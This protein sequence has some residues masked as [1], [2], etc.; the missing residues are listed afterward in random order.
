M[1]RKKKKKVVLS[2]IKLD[3]NAW[4]LYILYVKCHS[5]KDITVSKISLSTIQNKSEH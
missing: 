3:S 2:T 4:L 1:I 5:Q